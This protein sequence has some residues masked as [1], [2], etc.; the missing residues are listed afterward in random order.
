MGEYNYELYYQITYVQGARDKLTLR[1][2]IYRDRQ[3]NE[4]WILY[5]VS[6]RHVS[7]KP[8]ISI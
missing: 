5:T 3:T 8:R 2:H 6:K 7:K 1:F 4:I